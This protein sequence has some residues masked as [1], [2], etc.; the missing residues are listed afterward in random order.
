MSN[1]RA[2]R[3][4][5]ISVSLAGCLIAPVVFVVVCVAYQRESAEWFETVRLWNGELLAVYRSHS[6]RIYHGDPHA[7]GWGGGDPRSGA[8]FTTNGTTYRWRGVYIPIAIQKDASGVYIV[9][10]DRETPNRTGFRIYRAKDP[11]A[12]DE[13]PPSDFPKHLAIQNTWL[14]EDN[15]IGM[16]GK[17]QNQHDIVAKMDAGDY[18]FRESLTARL[19]SYLVDP[20]FKFENVPDEKFVREFKAKWIENGGNEP[21]HNP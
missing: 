4:V 9:T 1:G 10:F 17:V 19:W 5:A 7:F 14:S 13:I 12:W 8:A 20:S 6:Q 16:D 18:W 11:S 3:K 2:M 15:G 21:P